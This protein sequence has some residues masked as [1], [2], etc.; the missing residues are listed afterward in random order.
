MIMSIAYSFVYLTCC[1]AFDKS[2]IKFIH[3]SA[4]NYKDNRVNTIYWLLGTVVLLLIAITVYDLFALHNM[5]DIRWLENASKH[6]DFNYNIP[7]Y[8]FYGSSIIFYNYIIVTGSMFTTKFLSEYWWCTEYW[9]RV[10]RCVISCGVTVGIILLF[11]LIHTND[12]TSEY[13]F[14]YIIPYVISGFLYSAVFP[15][16]FAKCGLA[17]SYPPD[18]VDYELSRL[19]SMNL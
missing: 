18:M 7:S 13:I 16:L 14:C 3:K 9:K 19:E 12:T 11:S 4:F 15:I 10:V 1:F 17:L 2:L 8:S 6:C 5:I